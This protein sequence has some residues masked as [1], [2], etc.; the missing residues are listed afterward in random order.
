M[1]Q[2][3]KNQHCQ[4]I[5]LLWSTLLTTT[6]SFWIN[7]SVTVE[8]VAFFQYCGQRFLV[9]LYVVTSLT[10]DFL[11]F[12]VYFYRMMSH[13]NRR[14]A[15][16]FTEW[17]ERT[18][19]KKCCSNNLILPTQ[20]LQLYLKWMYSCCFQLNFCYLPYNSYNLNSVYKSLKSSANTFEVCIPVLTFPTFDI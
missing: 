10:K 14:K 16:H 20:T 13:M 12:K 6:S 9:K 7:Y 8:A 2:N 11:W 4:L 15:S 18:Y 5:L 19:P 1:Y 17:I 3:S